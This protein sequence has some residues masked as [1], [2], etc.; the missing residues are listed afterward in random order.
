MT[1]GKASDI[2]SGGIDGDGGVVGRHVEV[3]MA[4]RQDIQLCLLVVER[5][6]KKIDVEEQVQLFLWV[7]S[8]YCW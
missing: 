6:G 1:E 5:R 4:I 8:S 2:H 7:Q 3:E